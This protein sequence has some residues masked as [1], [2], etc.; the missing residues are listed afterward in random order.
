[1]CT[2]IESRERL[3]DAKLDSL[4]KHVDRKKAKVDTPRMVKGNIYYYPK[5]VH[6]MLPIFITM[7]LISWF[8][9]RLGKR[10]RRMS[11]FFLVLY[12]LKDVVPWQI[13]NPSRISSIF[14][15]SKTCP[16]NI[17]LISWVGRLQRIHEWFSIA[18][19]KKGGERISFPCSFC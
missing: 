3:L 16:R 5:Y 15:K 12:L 8:W 17:S 14:S 13:M 6:Y 4:Y 11:N 7:W 19:H 9:G 18:T 2:T 1:M 10:K